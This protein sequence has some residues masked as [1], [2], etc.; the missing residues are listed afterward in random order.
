MVKVPSKGAWVVLEEY[1]GAVFAG[2]ITLQGEN[3]EEPRVML[4]KEGK[5]EWDEGYGNGIFIIPL[6]EFR[7]K[8]IR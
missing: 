8:R 1:G 4:K 6:E 2:G 7:E 5:P 3:G